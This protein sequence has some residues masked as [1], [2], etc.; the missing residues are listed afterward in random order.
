[1]R[2]EWFPPRSAGGERKEGGGGRKRRED[3]IAR[4]GLNVPVAG[5]EVLC[6]PLDVREM[7][8]ELLQVGE[9]VFRLDVERTDVNA[10]HQLSELRVGGDGL[11]QLLDLLEGRKDDF[12][13]EL[14]GGGIVQL[15]RDEG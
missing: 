11:A 10:L 12:A 2:R 7:G 4:E 3:V 5:S 15:L 1:V 13:I 6:Q 9:G 8:E 14:G